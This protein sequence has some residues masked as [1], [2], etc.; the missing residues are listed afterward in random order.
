M[1]EQNLKKENKL[2]HQSA[3]LHYIH[4]IQ[5]KKKKR[6]TPPKKTNIVVWACIIHSKDANKTK[7]S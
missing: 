2:K 4:K 5:T 6:A 1:Y 7:Q 3:L